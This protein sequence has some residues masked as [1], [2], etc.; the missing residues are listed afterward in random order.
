MP[1]CVPD[2]EN[3]LLP[4]EPQFQPVTVQCVHAA[5]FDN[6]RP[7]IVDFT[8]ATCVAG[9]VMAVIMGGVIGHL[10]DADPENPR[11]RG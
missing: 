4:A 2:E 1:R 11:S 5:L 3:H 8:I 6:V 7:Y 10:V 9:T